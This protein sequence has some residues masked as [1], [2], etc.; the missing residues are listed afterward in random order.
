[1]KDVLSKLTVVIILQYSH[2]SNHYIVY[3]PHNTIQ[4]VY[5]IPRKLGGKAK[6]IHSGK[7]ER[8]LGMCLPVQGIRDQLHQV[9]FRNGTGQ[10][11]DHDLLLTSFQ[12]EKLE[13]PLFN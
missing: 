3:L 10:L 11:C 9:Y 1:M 8:Q 2:V 6:D 13:H 5:Y 4:Y 7:C 12:L